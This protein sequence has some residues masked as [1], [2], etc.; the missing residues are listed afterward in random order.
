MAEILTPDIC[1]IGGGSGA[2]AT[3]ITA[4]AFGAPVVL[5]ARRVGGGYRDNLPA[6]AAAARRA[7]AARGSASRGTRRTRGR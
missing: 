4:V 3:A 1:V 6:L 5:V 2:A 7:A